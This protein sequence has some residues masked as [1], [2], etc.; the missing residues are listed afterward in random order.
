[1]GTNQSKPYEFSI[2]EVMQ[3]HAFVLENSKYEAEV[4]KNYTITTSS[5]DSSAYVD[6]SINIT[7]FQ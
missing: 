7:F 4:H 3:I 5:I 6:F 1:M 2:Y